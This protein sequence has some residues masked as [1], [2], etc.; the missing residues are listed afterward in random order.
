MRTVLKRLTATALAAVMLLACA[1]GV[2]AAAEEEEEIFVYGKTEASVVKKTVPY[3][4]DFGEQY[5]GRKESETNIYFVD[6]GN[7]P[8]VAVSEYM[9]L[10]RDVVLM[11]HE[12]VTID[13]QV[14]GPGDDHPYGEHYYPVFRPDNESLMLL[15]TE[16]NTIYFSNFNTFAQNP[17]YSALVTAMD[18]PEPKTADIIELFE[19]ALELPPEEQKQLSEE[20]SNSLK[21]EKNTLFTLQTESHNV[22]GSPVELDLSEYLIDLV[23]QDGECYVPLQT[24]TDLFMSDRYLFFICT[25][26]ALYAFEYDSKLYQEL[27]AKEPVEMSLDFAIFNYNE[28]RFSLDIHYGLKAEHNISDFGSFL[29]NTDLVTDLAG[30][31]SAKFDKAV[32]R[33]TGY[34]FDDLHSGSLHPS[35]RS[36]EQ[37]RLAFLDTLTNIGPSMKNMSRVDSKFEAARKAAYPETVPMYEEIGDTAF[38]TFD[39]FALLTDDNDRAAY[40]DQALA[41]DPSEFVIRQKKELSAEEAVK[42]LEGMTDGGEDSAEEPAEPEADDDEEDEEE[43][44]VDTIQLFL[45]AYRQITRENSP[46]KNVVIDL[47]NN[48]G[49]QADAAVFVISWILGQGNIALNDM[50]TG[51][52]TIMTY[53]ADVNL[54]NE[55]GD[56]KDC[57]MDLGINVYVMMS[58]ASFSCGNLV[59]AACRMSRQVTLI[60]QTSGGGSCI[61][62]PCNSASGTIFQISGSKQLATVKNGSFYNID[63]GIEPDIVLTKPESFYDR[64]APVGYLH[65]VK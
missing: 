1:A 63:E 10:L 58:P 11:G 47:S 27:E 34:Y 33:L 8:Y 37:G 61:V 28:L 32:A 25:G 55:Y 49:G 26:D 40:Y 13:Y 41:P 21:P 30:T 9:S 65:S 29:V 24:M 48:G 2:A 7:I 4:T 14:R 22:A 51:A 15:N 35:W 36:G 64:P 31:D 60:G 20:F 44:K 18:L 50:F 54:N 17:K 59:P 3:I 43:E 62:L 53:Q 16:Y 6:G 57:M 19:K 38:I 39:S 12:D 45:Y 56:G 23:E 52:E 46:I 5:G 42:M